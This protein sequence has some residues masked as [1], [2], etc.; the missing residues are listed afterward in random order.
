MVKRG[1]TKGVWRRGCGEGGVWQKE[2]DKMGCGKMEC[3]KGVW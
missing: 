1:V 2:C 3:G